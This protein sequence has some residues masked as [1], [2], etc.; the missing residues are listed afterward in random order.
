[1]LANVNATT[2]AGREL[3]QMK[4][5]FVPFSART[6]MSGVSL[7]SIGV[8][9]HVFRKRG[10][11]HRRSVTASDPQNSVQTNRMLSATHN[12]SSG[13]ERNLV[14][15]R[16]LNSEE[17]LRFCCHTFAR[18]SNAPSSCRLHTTGQSH[19]ESPSERMVR[20]AP[21]KSVGAIAEIRA[22]G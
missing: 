15:V 6:R 7:D 2:V 22:T 8:R 3:E 21:T 11:M 16:A 9:T 14:S 19:A 10:G 12:V 4:P 5:E 18:F 13:T 1:M 20:L 17:F